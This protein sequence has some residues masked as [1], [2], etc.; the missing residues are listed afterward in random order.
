MYTVPSRKPGN[1]QVNQGMMLTVVAGGGARAGRRPP[2]HIPGDGTQRA[3]GGA[4]APV[5][6]HHTRQE[7]CAHPETIAWCLNQRA[8]VVLR[9]RLCLL[10][11][12]S[13][14]E[15][16]LSSLRIRIVHE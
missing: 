12:Y 6:C 3:V 10:L 5:H 7:Q 11:E 15:L 9:M 1:C 16:H 14:N 13:Y 2:Q 4:E 8:S